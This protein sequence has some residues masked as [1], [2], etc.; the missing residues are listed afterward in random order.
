VG[1]RPDRLAARGADHDLFPPSALS[2]GR[3]CPA[4]AA[5]VDSHPQICRTSYC[6]TSQ[7]HRPLRRHHPTTS[8][9]RSTPRRCTDKARSGRAINTPNYEVLQPSPEPCPSPPPHI[10]SSTTCGDALTVELP[11][12]TYESGKTSCRNWQG[13]M[14]DIVDQR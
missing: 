11:K 8:P 2:R 3:T 7:T 6:H 4:V 1:D 9:Q 12:T 10:T 14:A 5:V 13:D